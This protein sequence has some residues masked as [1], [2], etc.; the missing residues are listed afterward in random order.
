MESLFEYLISKENKD[1]IS[2]V[3]EFSPS[4]GEIIVSDLTTGDISVTYSNKILLF[5][6][7]TY[8]RKNKSIVDKLYGFSPINDIWIEVNINNGRIDIDNIDDIEDLMNNGDL[9]QN[10]RVSWDPD[11]NIKT[12]YRDPYFLEEINKIPFDKLGKKIV[13]TLKK[14]RL[15]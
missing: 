5:L 15:I 1:K 2:R 7:E 10:M 14:L 4:R 8:M 12:V 9:T 11:D 6:G 13:P 3:K